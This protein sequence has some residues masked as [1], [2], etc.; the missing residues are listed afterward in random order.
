MSINLSFLH[1]FFFQKFPKFKSILF[2]ILSSP[3]C[4]YQYLL[5]DFLLSDGFKISDLKFLIAVWIISPTFRRLSPYFH[6]KPSRQEIVNEA[7]RHGFLND[8]WNLDKGDDIFPQLE[9]NHIER[10]VVTAKKKERE[11]GEE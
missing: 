1:I 4:E 6:W 2:T 10:E 5:H 8:S 11:R 3:P 9:E 7:W